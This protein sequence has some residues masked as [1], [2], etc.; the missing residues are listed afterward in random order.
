MTEAGG[1]LSSRAT[2]G[3][4]R[5]LYRMGRGATIAII[6]VIVLALAGAGL[7]AG[8]LLAEEPDL[9]RG[10]PEG[11]AASALSFPARIGAAAP[12]LPA[13]ARFAI[14]SRTAAGPRAAV[15]QPAVGALGQ[16]Q[17]S[18][19]ESGGAAPGST[20]TGQTPGQTPSPGPP[21]EDGGQVVTIGPDVSVPV[22]SD[23]IVLFQDLD[24]VG[25]I[26]ASDGDYF[27]AIVGQDDPS[28]DAAAVIEANF[29]TFVADNEGLVDLQTGDIISLDPF[30]SMV[31]RAAI[32]YNAV[33]ADAQ[34]SYPASGLFFANVRQDGLVLLM[35]VEVWDVTSEEEWNAH[36]PHWAPAYVGAVESYAGAPLPVS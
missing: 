6:V 32:P 23:W 4:D 13:G 7:L 9:R 29:T 20:P 35:I 11:E 1:D 34:A 27:F 25:I 19:V 18:P 31:S 36:I 14:G 17:P 24:R 28:A 33:Y 30:G 2:P 16:L 21:P 3:W 12:A 5:A 22:P 8:A 15:L 26:N 10:G